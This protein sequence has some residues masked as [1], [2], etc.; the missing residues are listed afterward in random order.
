MTSRPFECL[1]SSL[2][3]KSV[4]VCLLLAHN[5]V[6]T[7]PRLIVCGRGSLRRPMCPTDVTFYVMY[8]DGD[9]DRV[10]VP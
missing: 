2:Y 4:S 9:I 7:C 6:N 5:E 1:K 10:K 3:E 8:I